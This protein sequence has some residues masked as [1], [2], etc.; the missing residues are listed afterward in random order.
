MCGRTALT[1]HNEQI[2]KKCVF[3]KKPK[4][5]QA[6]NIRTLSLDSD[7]DVSL[8]PLWSDANGS[9]TPSPNIAPSVHT[10]VLRLTRTND[11]PQLRLEPMMWGLVPPWH[12]GPSPT[13]HGLSTNNC[14]VEGVQASKLY[15]PC[16]PHRRCVVVCEGF[17][18]WRRWTWCGQVMVTSDWLRVLGMEAISSLT[19]CTDLLM[20]MGSSLCST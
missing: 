17:Y 5:P 1:L 10:P 19:S 15:S 7:P 2:L 12:P 8:V 18:E 4:K 3:K 13:S 9:W 16:L 6:E 20:R 14:R 11:Q